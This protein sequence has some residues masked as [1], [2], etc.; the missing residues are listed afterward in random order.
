V[1]CQYHR[2]L[3]GEEEEVGGIQDIQSHS[4]TKMKVSHYVHRINEL[5]T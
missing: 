5:V 2:G 1:G 3:G 4:R